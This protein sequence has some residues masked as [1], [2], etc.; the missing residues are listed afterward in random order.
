MKFESA[1]YVSVLCIKNKL[2]RYEFIALWCPHKLT[3]LPEI[4]RQ[5]INPRAFYSVVCHTS[6][7]P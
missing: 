7:R 3:G 4:D 6:A 2:E 5:Y 1:M